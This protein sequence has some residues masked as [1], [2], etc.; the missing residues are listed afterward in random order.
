MFYFLSVYGH[1]PEPSLNLY[2]INLFKFISNLF[3]IWLIA[4]TNNIVFVQ[5]DINSDIKEMYPRRD[6]IPPP[7]IY[8]NALALF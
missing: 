1:Q 5:L 6:N 3:N 4:K 2:K 8:I 7:F